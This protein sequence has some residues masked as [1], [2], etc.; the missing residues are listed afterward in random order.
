MS[1]KKGC[2]TCK[3][4]SNYL[5]LSCK[6]CSHMFC[7]SCLLP[8]IHQCSAMMT[9]KEALLKRHTER[10]HSEKCV[11]EKINKC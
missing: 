9:M 11:A 8:E 5:K 1:K 2:R 10:L 6:F 3:T 7:T 4:S